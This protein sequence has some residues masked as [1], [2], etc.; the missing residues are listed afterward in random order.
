VVHLLQ[1]SLEKGYLCL[2]DPASLE[3]L[4]GNS[5][6]PP[7]SM[8]ETRFEREDG[9]QIDLDWSAVKAVFFVSSFKG[10]SEHQPIR[11][12]ANGPCIESIWVEIVFRD[13]E[14]IEGC[15]Q[16]SLRHLVDDVFFLYPSAPGSNNLLVYVN[17]ASISSYRVL[18]VRMLEDQ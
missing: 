11:F 13:G 18:G 5:S 3:I 16:N 15:V 2:D 8:M 1:G 6:V 4:S 12:Y 10:N 7:K 17:K 9:T 14:V